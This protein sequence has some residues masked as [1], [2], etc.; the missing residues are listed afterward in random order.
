LAGV[1][2]APRNTRIISN[3]TYPVQ[4]SS[5]LASNSWTKLA[6]IVARPTNR[7]ETATDAGAD[8]NRYYRVVTPRQP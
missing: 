4:H 2:S 1:A 5:T 8:T 6:D 3:K 7:T